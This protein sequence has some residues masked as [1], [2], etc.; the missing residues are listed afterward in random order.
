MA[1]GAGPS[2]R[3]LA[4]TT[5]MPTVLFGIGQGAI[6]PVLALSAR[7]RG[8]SL[9]VAGLVVAL[10]GI[11]RLLGDL[12]AGQL[13]IRL[14]ER[15]ALLVSAGLS[16]AAMVVCASGSAVWSLALGAVA[17]GASTALFGVARHAYLTET[18]PYAVRARVMSSVAGA[19][20]VGL[21][22]GP[23]VTALATAH[24]SL[25]A[26]YWINLAVAGVVVVLVL[27]MPDDIEFDLPRGAGSPASTRGIARE[28]LRLLG[29]LGVV[30]LTVGAV[31]SVRPVALPLWAEHLGLG[32][33]ETSLVFGLA[34]A[35]DMALF[36]PA[37]AVMDRLGRLAVAIPS[38]LLLGAGTAALPLTHD[39][40]QL[41]IVA[42]VLG[43]ANGIGSGLVLTIGADVS[44]AVGRAEFLSMW[45]FCAD[46]GQGGGP[47][48]VGVL[49][50][51]AGLSTAFA[52]VG[53][54]SVLSAAG[55]ARWVPRFSA[56][57]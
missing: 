24:S 46:V 54:L 16:A 49:G 38:M 15:N 18:L 57:E 50:G 40:A 37:G 45:R 17:S 42:V 39:R 4:A 3:S 9:T 48:L 7:D 6:L 13:L 53:V 32:P 8:A 21:F 25:E 34:A 56:R 31:R 52:S 41:I 2:R 51:A 14:G 43:A 11:G 44:P 28:H 12:P 20:R 22:V 26:A 5:F 27:L 33:T 47:L 29:T 19:N 55:L 35:V 1:E 10:I 30:I 23:F 36:Y